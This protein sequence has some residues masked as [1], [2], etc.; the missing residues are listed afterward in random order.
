MIAKAVSFHNGVPQ[1]GIEPGI[2]GTLSAYASDFQAPPRHVMTR[3]HCARQGRR[4]IDKNRALIVF[5]FFF[6]HVTRLGG[7]LPDYLR[8]WTMRPF[9]FTVSDPD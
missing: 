3:V 6:A 2:A 4:S 7:L 5:P 1:D 8:R 9:R